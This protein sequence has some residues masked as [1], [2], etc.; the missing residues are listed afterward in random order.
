M[1]KYYLIIDG[2]NKSS[3]TSCKLSKYYL[4]LWSIQELLIVVNT[5]TLSRHWMWL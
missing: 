1:P 3:I 2:E 4:Q 5:D